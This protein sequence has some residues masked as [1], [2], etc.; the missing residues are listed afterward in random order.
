MR[1]EQRVPLRTRFESTSLRRRF[2]KGKCWP[3][4]DSIAWLECKFAAS[5]RHG[6][7]FPDCVHP[8]VRESKR[9]ENLRFPSAL[10]RM[11]PDT[12]G[13]RAEVSLIAMKYLRSPKGDTRHQS[14]LE[15]TCCNC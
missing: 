15:R 7:L 9:V 2:R 8:P 3:T 10:H 14:R 12:H 13:C 4:R 11:Y 5:R 1:G 6:S